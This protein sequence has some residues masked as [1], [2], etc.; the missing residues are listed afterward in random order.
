[1]SASNLEAPFPV[2]AVAAW[3]GTGKT[4]LLEQLLPMLRG[5]GLN[6]GVIKHAHHAFD[7]DKPGKD[8]YRL[9]SAGAAPMLV[10]SRERFA[11]MQDT[12]GQQEPDLERLVELMV[13]HRPDLVIAEGFKAWP[14]PKLVL[15]RD[16]VGDPAIFQDA[17][18]CAVACKRDERD[19]LERHSP[20][21]SATRLDLD[22]VAAVAR[23]IAQ[24]VAEQPAVEPT[25][26]HSNSEGDRTCS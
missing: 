21:R 19:A 22:D 7:V 9:R 10:A 4:T 23:W 26:E 6:V 8:S 13:P 3:S 2:L 12:P 15:Y 11:L 1:M 17:W 5:Y 16:G 24:W 20:K 14:L 25:V 18:V